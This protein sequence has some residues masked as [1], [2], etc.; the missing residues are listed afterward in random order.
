MIL[1]KNSNKIGHIEA[2]WPISYRTNNHIWQGEPLCPNDKTLR[3]ATNLPNFLYHFSPAQTA[4]VPISTA[5]MP[6]IYRLLNGWAKTKR[7]VGCTAKPA[8]RVS[9]NAKVRLCSTPNYPKS[10]WY[11]LSNASAMAAPS[12][13]RQISVRLI[14]APGAA[15]KSSGVIYLLM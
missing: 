12:K 14:V 7:F 4:T 6:A 8:A 10:M 1:V 13:Q 9:A 15:E 3:T 2:F 11:A 5:L